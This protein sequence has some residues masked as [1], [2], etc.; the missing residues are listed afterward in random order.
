M[1]F[2]LRKNYCKLKNKKVRFY[3]Q[4]RDVLGGLLPRPKNT[5][6]FNNLPSSIARN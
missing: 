6:K 1:T 5:I 2:T 4:E 3:L